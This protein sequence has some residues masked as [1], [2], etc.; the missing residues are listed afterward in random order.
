MIKTEIELPEEIFISTKESVL[1]FTNN[2][3]LIY[4]VELFKNRKLSLGN[5]AKLAGIPRLQFYDYLNKKKVSFI[6]WDEE[7]LKKELNL[8]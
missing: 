7:E 4:A 2:I 5:A 6:N 8:E 1:E 3:K